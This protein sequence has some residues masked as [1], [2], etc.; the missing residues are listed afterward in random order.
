MTP[1]LQ[2]LIIGAVIGAFIFIWALCAIAAKGDKH[3]E[4]IMEAEKEIFRSKFL[5]CRPLGYRMEQGPL[6]PAWCRKFNSQFY[7][8]DVHD[9]SRRHPKYKGPVRIRQRRAI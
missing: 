4:Q 3:L 6:K 9:V 8:D 7:N 5:R 1:F 2:T